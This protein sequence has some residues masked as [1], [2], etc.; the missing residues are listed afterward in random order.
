MA[1]SVSDMAHS[2]SSYMHSKA[3]S[4]PKQ[5]ESPPVPKLKFIEMWS[6]FDRLVSK[7]DEDAVDDLNIDITN[8]IAAAIKKK[9]ETQ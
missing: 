8:L 1:E 5:S 4:S 6:N 9:R 3:I 2:F 7:L